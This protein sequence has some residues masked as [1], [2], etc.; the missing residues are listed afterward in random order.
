MFYT[1]LFNPRPGGGAAEK[2]NPDVPT[3]GERFTFISDVA[4][5][6]LPIKRVVNGT[7]GIFNIAV[8]YKIG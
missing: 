3:D 4:G 6:G 2:W 8:F 1:D 5:V 7:V